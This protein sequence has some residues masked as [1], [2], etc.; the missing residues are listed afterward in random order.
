[1]TTKNSITIA[2]NLSVSLVTKHIIRQNINFIPIAK[3]NFDFSFLVAL[4]SSIL[5]GL[6]IMN[7]PPKN[8]TQ[9][10][11]TLVHF[12]I[13]TLGP[14]PPKLSSSVV[15]AVVLFLHLHPLHHSNSESQYYLLHYQHYSSVW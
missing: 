15:A 11:T 5:G 14:A 2:T 1:M 12:M 7:K 6:N 4:F 9:T 3:T 8:E 10:V 13:R